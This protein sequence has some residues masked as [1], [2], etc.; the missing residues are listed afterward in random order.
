MA[1]SKAK[2]KAENEEP[3]RVVPCSN[4]SSQAAFTLG[5]SVNVVNYCPNCLP[6]H[7]VSAASAGEFP[8]AT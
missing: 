1:T 2:A 6:A 3:P 4:C 5:D 8:L 7:F